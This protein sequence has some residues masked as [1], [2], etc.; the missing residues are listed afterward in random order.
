MKAKY[1][2][3]LAALATTVLFTGCKQEEPFDTQS[4]DDAPLIL[5]PYETKSGLI[6]REVT[7]PDALVDSVIVTP[8]R[9]TTVNWYLDKE[10]VFTGT[11][12]NMAFPAGKYALTIEAVTEKG[13][14]T[15]RSGSL[16]VNPAA[17]APYAG[18]PAGGRHL[19]PGVDIP[20]SGKNLG[21]VAAIVVTRDIFGKDEVVTFAPTAV[22][23]DQ[24]TVNLP[25]LKDG[26]YY[27]RLKDTEGALHGSDAIQVHNASVVLEGYN[28]LEPGKQVVVTGVKL[29]DVA[30]VTLDETVITELTVTA[31][32]VAFVVP[33]L[34]VGEHTLSMKNADG[35]DV[36]FSTAHGTVTQVKISISPESTLWSGAV[37]LQWDADR[38]KVT[39]DQM[40]QVPVGASI[41]IYFEKLPDGDANMYEGAEYKQYYALRITTPWWDGYDLVGQMDMNEAPSPYTFTYTDERKATVETC[42]AM[43]LV[44]WGLQINK[45]TYK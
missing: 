4:A 37:A 15:S 22:T 14:R 28:N 34:E 9:Y 1:I 41:S 25:E 39:A 31:T 10:L 17:D 20:V 3:L 2:L 45:I 42:G 13:K 27:L 5:V 23:D 11:K 21:K 6:T 19:V 18:A 7:N 43:S 29:Q 35:S 26:T 30:S 16:T 44:G 36:L 32:S 40:A 33:A 38:V 8:S 12:I 24:L